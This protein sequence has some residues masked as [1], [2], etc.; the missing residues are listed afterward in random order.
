MSTRE[1]IRLIARAS[2]NPYT[3]ILYYQSNLRNYLQSSPVSYPYK[4]NVSFATEVLKQPGS[5][6]HGIRE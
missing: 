5:E 3:Y 4:I 6:I 1:N 2:F